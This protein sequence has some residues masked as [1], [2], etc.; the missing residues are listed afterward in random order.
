MSRTKSIAMTLCAAALF[1]LAMTHATAR[2]QRGGG[3]AAAPENFKPVPLKIVKR[4]YDTKALLATPPLTESQVKGRALWLQRCAYCH[5][6]VGQPTYKTMG[7][8]IGAETVKSLGDDA[9]KAF[10]NTGTVRMPSFKYD[11]DSQQLDDVIA[12]LKTVPST[13]KPTQNQLD[14]KAT[15]SDG[16]D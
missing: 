6:G 14:G 11:L 2:A 1:A 4:D 10:V 12:F 15:A 3:A 16:S 5:D 7:D 8:W 13:Q 9:F